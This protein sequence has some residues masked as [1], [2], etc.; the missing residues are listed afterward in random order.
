MARRKRQNRSRSVYQSIAAT[1]SG[2]RS[3]GPPGKGVAGMSAI[4]SKRSACPATASAASLP[5]SVAIAGLA[6]GKKGEKKA[7][8]EEMIDDLRNQRMLGEF[9]GEP[10]IDRAA[11]AEVLV[12][13]S[14]LSESDPDVLSADINPLIVSGGRPIAVDG[15]IEVRK[16]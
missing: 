9:R 3:A 14:R 4:R 12:G 2:E 16:R 1:R 13:L 6:L 7:D 5:A 15:L 11:L 10:A 8:A